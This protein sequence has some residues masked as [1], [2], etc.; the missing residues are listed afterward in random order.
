MFR[1]KPSYFLIA[2]TLFL[3]ELWI[4]LY[5]DDAFVRPYLGDVIV[6]L[7][8]YYSLRTILKISP[9]KLAI[10]TLLF[11]FLVEG[12]QYVEFIKWLGLADY[13]LAHMILGSSF[14][15]LD[16]LC[17][18]IGFV[19]LFIADKDLRKRIARK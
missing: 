12:L 19:V 1:F 4:A 15:W 13:H 11:S 5:V 14:S 6:I 10:F 18:I 3:V 8:I 17:Y 16:M 7:L 9:L 2:V